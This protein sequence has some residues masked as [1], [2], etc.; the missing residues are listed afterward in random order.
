MHIQSAA[1][2]GG[3][4]VAE[5]FVKEGAEAGIELRSLKATVLAFRNGLN[6]DWDIGLLQS[7]GK[8]FRLVIRNQRVCGA[9]RDEGRRII[10]GDIS[11]GRCCFGFVLVLLNRAADEFALG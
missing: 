3:I 5:V 1:L 11:D 10:T 7:D 4:H 2:D 8:G 6:I 9:M